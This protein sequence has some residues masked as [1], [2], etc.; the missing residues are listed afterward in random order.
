MT[1]PPPPAFEPET[2]GPEERRRLRTGFST[3]AAAA[4]AALGAARWLAEGRPP[5]RVELALPA[6]RRLTVELAEAGRDG[7]GDRRVMVIKD[8][9]DDPDVTHGA[10]ISAVVR[11]VRTPGLDLSGGPGV[12]R[13]TKPG[14]TLP[15]GQWA[16]NPGPR[17]IMRDNLAP[18]LPPDGPG[19]AVSLEVARG[20]ELA[21]KTLNPR[22]GVVGGL[23][24]LGTTGLVKPYSHGAYVAAIDS[25]MSVAQAARLREIVL[26]TG[27]RSEAFA[28]AV[29]PE[30]PE[31]SFVQMADFFRAALRLAARHGFAAVGVADFFGKAVKQAAGLDCTHAHRADLDLSLLAD[32]LPGLAPPLRRAVSTAPTALAALEVLK[33]G[34][35]LAAAD[36]VAARA[37]AAARAFLGPGPALWLRV[38]DFDGTT[39]ALVED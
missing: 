10:R 6:G 38:F 37:H 32:W 30:L 15:V 5:D 22:L 9:G 24:I 8:A 25:A 13:V 33:A 14:L 17:A 36:A 11:L 31:A 1:Y 28:Q 34:G 26:S 16:I 12:G 29:R 19:L 21:L 39:L 18:H 7:G 3:G 20:E 4:A 23:S 2:P 27:G 35:A